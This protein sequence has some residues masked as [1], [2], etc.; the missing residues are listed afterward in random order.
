MPQRF[1]DKKVVLTGGS[2]GL[3]LATTERLVAEGAQVLI[4]S[5]NN[6]ELEQAAKSIDADKVTYLAGDLADPAFCK[7]LI[8]RAV[9]Q[10]GRIDVLINNAG[11]FDEALF[12]DIELENWK[13]VMDVMLQAPYLL[14]QHAAK[15]MIENGGGAIVHLSSIDGHNVDGPYT[16]YSAA[17]AGL[18][19][20]S[21][22]I[23]VELGA[24]GIRSNTV[25]PGWALTPMVEAASSPEELETMKTAFERV[26]LKRMVMPEEVASAV[27]YLASD[28]ASGITGT[29]LIVD[30]G[31]VADLWIV[32]SLS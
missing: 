21:K 16:S 29:D 2:K 6:D 11:V 24:K 30:C 4:A 25:S 14:S 5:R 9:E 13:F 15:V 3:G 19:Q 10:W 26:P 7:A 18:M 32:P 27:C 31:T 12:L 1:E 17:K 20:L 23:A 22:N 8:D 28:D